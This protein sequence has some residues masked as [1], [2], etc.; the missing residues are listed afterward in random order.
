VARGGA[1][2]QILG[3]SVSR[4]KLVILKCWGCES[5]VWQDPVVVVVVFWRVTVARPG[6]GLPHWA[7]QPFR[8]TRAAEHVPVVAPQH[9][10]R[11]ISDLAVAACVHREHR[12]HLV[13]HQ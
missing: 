4:A 1:A 2:N 10:Q 7:L 6:Y 3:L 9:V 12:G 5:G 13:H 11:Y 8:F